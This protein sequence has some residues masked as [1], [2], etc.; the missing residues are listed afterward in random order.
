LPTLVFIL[1]GGGIA[2][3]VTPLFPVQYV[4]PAL[5]TFMTFQLASYA[6]SDAAM[7]ERV[8]ADIRGRVV[9]IFLLIAGT[10]SSTAPYVM[11]WCTDRLGERATQPLAYLPIF[12]GL[13][14]MMLLAIGVVPLIH[15]L[16]VVTGPPIDPITETTPRTV[17]AVL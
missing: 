13:G 14:V 10:F 7:L 11:G 4:L 16:G 8:P 6:V 15:A 3:A 2:V 9:G 12:V 5:M 17:E 1:I